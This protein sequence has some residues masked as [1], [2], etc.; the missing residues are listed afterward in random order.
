[1]SRIKPAKSYYVTSFRLAIRSPNDVILLFPA[2]AR[3]KT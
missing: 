2:S 3:E 1:M